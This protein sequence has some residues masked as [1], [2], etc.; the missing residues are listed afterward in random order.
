MKEEK[1]LKDDNC[2]KKSFNNIKFKF[3]LS[4]IIILILSTIISN[5]IYTLLDYL[6]NINPKYGV[7]IST[8]INI[9]ILILFA[10]IFISTFLMKNMK[11]I[12]KNVDRISQGDLTGIE[13]IKK[14]DEFGNI[15]K[16]LD[17]ITLNLRNM[18][19]EVKS[20]SEILAQNA[21]NLSEVVE[22]TTKSIE[23]ITTNINEIASG[24]DET[25]KNIV[26]LNET[27]LDFTKSTENTDENTK[28]VLN[29]SNSMEQSALKGKEDMDN[30][31]EKI[32]LMDDSTHKT[33]E[34]I[35]DLNNQIKDIDNIVLIIDDIAEQTNLLALNAAIEA[36]R[37]GEYGQGFAVVAEEIRKLAD[38]THTYSEEISKITNSVTNKSTHAVTSIENVDTIVNES[39][40]VANTA[41][42]SF[43]QLL[44]KIEEISKLINEIAN[45][46]K[47]QKDN[48]HLILEKATE[49][50]AISQ[51]TTAASENSVSA[52][53]K[54]LANMEEITASIENL[55]QIANNLNKM[56][57]KFKI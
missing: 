39:V 48:S 45:E 46:A 56:V 10:Y 19:G 17:K 12:L 28:T 13:A 18:V 49:I 55:S 35:G 6:M 44:Q 22:D 9:G 21:K 5:L 2:K 11:K 29:F 41:K 37:A 24:S 8:L 36:A 14:K 27:M 51:E 40:N 3:T 23:N 38:E 47:S 30:I 50:S 15:N 34:I 7:F 25:S 42:S 33:S 26:Y 32:N 57:E 31:I 54:N 1:I 53:E 16:S 52:I 20:H 4:I 43:E